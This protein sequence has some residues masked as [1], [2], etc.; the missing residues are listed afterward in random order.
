VVERAML[1]TS[2]IVTNAVIHAAT[3]VELHARVED[4]VLRVA[5]EDGDDRVPTA[6]EEAGPEGG[7]GLHIVEELAEA[8]GV[9]RLAH[10]KAVWFE[11]KLAPGSA[12]ADADL[13]RAFG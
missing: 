5:V 10:G 2:E 4:G 3:R 12:R 6:L 13:Q 11:V 9:T 8:W 7:F 1:L